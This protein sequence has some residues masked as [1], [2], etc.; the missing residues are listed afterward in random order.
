MFQTDCQSQNGSASEFQSV[1]QKAGSR[2]NS[3]IVEF[4]GMT[5]G[6]LEFSRDSPRRHPGIFLS[7][8]KKISGIPC[9]GG[10]Y[11]FAKT[12]PFTLTLTLTLYLG[13]RVPED[14]MPSLKF[15]LHTHSH[16]HS[17]FTSSNSNF[18]N[19]AK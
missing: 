15:N 17:D 16:S 5:S 9:F 18:P 14:N 1:F 3:P 8:T 11:A 19:F 6:G 4:S 2:I 12:P 10:Q 13:S 7:T